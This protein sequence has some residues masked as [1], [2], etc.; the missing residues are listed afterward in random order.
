MNQKTVLNKEEKIQNLINILFNDERFIRFTDEDK[1]TV[2]DLV[3]YK[4]RDFND[5]PKIRK[6]YINGIVK[7]LI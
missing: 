7:G 3:I 1:K 5:L 2:I 6:I 4:G